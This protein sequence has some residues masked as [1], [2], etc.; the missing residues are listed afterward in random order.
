MHI[1][2]LQRHVVL[3]EGLQRTENPPRLYPSSLQPAAQFKALH[4]PALLLNFSGISS[5]S[6]A[7]FAV[8][9]GL[10]ILAG[11]VSQL[12][13]RLG[14]YVALLQPFLLNNWMERD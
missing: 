10:S 13:I 5:F 7:S 4:Y 1:G 11:H 9:D 2:L 6:E 12:Q 8:I 14:R 3:P